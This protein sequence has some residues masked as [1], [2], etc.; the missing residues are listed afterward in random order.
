MRW[1]GVLNLEY[2]E[3][4]FSREFPNDSQFGIRE[5]RHTGILMSLSNKSIAFSAAEPFLQ[6]SIELNRIWTTSDLLSRD[7]HNWLCWKTA[8]RQ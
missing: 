6:C 2:G 4:R 3:G 5:C 8:R 1:A 7:K